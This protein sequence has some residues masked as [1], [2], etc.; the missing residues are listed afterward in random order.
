MITYNCKCGN[1]FTTTT[2]VGVQDIH[3][4]EDAEM[5]DYAD[6]FMPIQATTI[7]SNCLDTPKDMTYDSWAFAQWFNDHKYEATKSFINPIS[8][9]LE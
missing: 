4:Y 6:L 5:Y 3:Y 8:G 9:L 7:C 2:N 1:S